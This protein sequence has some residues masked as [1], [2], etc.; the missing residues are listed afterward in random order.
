MIS[1]S[2]IHLLSYTNAD[3]A[4]NS[5]LISPVTPRDRRRLLIERRR[6]RIERRYRRIEWLPRDRRRRCPKRR[7]L[8]IERRR[9]RIERRYRCIE[10]RVFECFMMFHNVLRVVHD[11]LQV[12]HNVLRCITMF[13]TCFMMF[14]YVWECLDSCTTIGIAASA[15]LERVLIS[16]WLVTLLHIFG[17]IP[18]PQS[19][20]SPETP[21]Q[22]RH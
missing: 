5:A 18:T 4:G 7:R 21:R 6:L 15:G 20:I 13:Y 9:L 22:Y 19:L 17:V 2:V 8:H 1:N 3:I 16:P 12:V 10:W 14:Y 11:V